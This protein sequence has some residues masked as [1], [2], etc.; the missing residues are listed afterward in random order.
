[1]YAHVRTSF[2]DMPVAWPVA[3]TPMTDRVQR[4][5]R[6]LSPGKALDRL[7]GRLFDG[8]TD[9]VRNQVGGFATRDGA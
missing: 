5:T 8:G 1:V 7:G 6:A 4:S 2:D 3:V 9:A